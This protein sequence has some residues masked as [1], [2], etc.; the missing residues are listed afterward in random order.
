MRMALRP[1]GYDAPDPIRARYWQAVEFPNQISPAM[2][3]EILRLAHKSFRQ[4]WDDVDA[5][6]T[7]II[8]DRSRRIVKSASNRYYAGSPGDTAYG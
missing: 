4:Y 6:R 1:Q 7:F 8:T 5:M 2:L 3:V